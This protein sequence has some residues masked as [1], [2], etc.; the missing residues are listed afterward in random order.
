MAVAGA[1]VLGRIGGRLRCRLGT[2]VRAHSQFWRSTVL[3]K[4][5][6]LTYDDQSDAGQLAAGDQLP[7]TAAAV[8]PCGMVAHI[9]GE[10][11]VVGSGLDPEAVQKLK[12]EA[13][14]GVKEILD[15]LRRD[16]PKIVD[17]VG[18]AVGSTLGGAASYTALFFGGK[19]VGL[20]AV[21]ITTGLKAAGG[22]VGGGM[23]A[24]VAVL[25]VP[26]VVLG[27]AGYA[28][29]NRRRKARLAAAL[30]R[31]IEKLYSIQER[32]VANAEYFREELAEIKAYI[33]QFE[34][35]RP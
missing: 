8:P 3:A 22:L 10:D 2:G 29:V 31:A 19:Q 4:E 28:I 7:V 16:Y 26:V 15:E 35:K 32:L 11:T 13:R 34:K 18:A 12:D 17:A 23:A 33:D 14:E 21:G 20:S 24:G 1:G 27:V 9:G 6:Q 30:S 5:E 25:A